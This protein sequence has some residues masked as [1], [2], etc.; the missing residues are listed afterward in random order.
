[1][2]GQIVFDVSPELLALGL[3]VEC[4]VIRNLRNVVSDERFDRVW[5]REVDELL[6]RLTSESIKADPVLLG[7][8]ALHEAA[9][10]GN[11][12]NVA[13][14]ENLLH[15]LL[16]TGRLPRINLAVDIYNLISVKTGLSCGAHDIARVSGNIHLRRTL[17]TENFKPLGET[18]SKLVKA[19]EYGYIDDSNDM[20][21]RL[22]ARQCDKSKV[23]IDTRDCFF[24]IQGNAAT[25]VGY[26][27]SAA[28]ELIDRITSYCGG[29][30]EIVWSR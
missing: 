6:G 16:R 10:V 23:V 3:R 1:M 28:D 22:E 13:A 4:I 5:D 7:F 18:E 25:E 26:I 14:S 15:L 11:R 8:R 19:G 12:R 20:L 30:A 21:C 24:I 17:G 2:Q 27:S 9:G 29:E